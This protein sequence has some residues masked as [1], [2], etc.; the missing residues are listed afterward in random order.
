MVPV[1]GRV[2]VPVEKSRHRPY[3]GRRR[4]QKHDDVHAP[5]DSSDIVLSDE[6]E[7]R[8]DERE[9]G[10]E[11]KHRGDDS[12]LVGGVDD[13]G[14]LEDRHDSHVEAC[15]D[16]S[17]RHP[18][19][20]VIHVA[21]QQRLAGRLAC[22]SSEEDDQALDP[23]TLV[24]ECE[25]CACYARSEGGYGHGVQRVFVRES[26]KH[27]VG[28]F[29][30]HLP[31]K[32]V[33]EVIE[34]VY[35]FGVDSH[36]PLLNEFRPE[37]P[38]GEGGGGDF[39]VGDLDGDLVD[40]HCMCNPVHAVFD[41]ESRSAGGQQHLAESHHDAQLVGKAIEGGNVVVVSLL[42]RSTLGRA[43]LGRPG[44]SGGSDS[45]HSDKQFTDLLRGPKVRGVQV[46]SNRDRV[47]RPPGGAICAAGLLRC[48]SEDWR[49]AGAGGR[50][51]G[52]S[53]STIKW[54]ALR[55]RDSNSET[56][57]DRLGIWPVLR[58][59]STCENSSGT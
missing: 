53:V 39:S 50:A 41:S 54:L 58:L 40:A 13:I 25:A 10:D 59:W 22:Q 43:G 14:Y 34:V 46:S 28:V 15:G 38:A 33:D 1:S 35:A 9:A 16:E 2:D 37:R 36:D 30:Q 3:G 56:N 29:D 47:D 19:G 49:K 24:E 27:V 21:A 8:G 7:Y 23:A 45:N 17:A 4:D 11:E 31:G 26:V 57:S 5:R 52:K 51:P 12:G 32:V 55:D 44:G 18:H 48:V 6:I 20:E 42:H